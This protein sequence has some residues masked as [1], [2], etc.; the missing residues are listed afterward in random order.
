MEAGGFS[1][2]GADNHFLASAGHRDDKNTRNRPSTQEN[3]FICD[4]GFTHARKNTQGILL[5]YLTPVH[6]S[7]WLIKV[8]SISLYLRPSTR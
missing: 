1:N 4:E 6:V 5:I 3:G 2:R 7:L 8:K